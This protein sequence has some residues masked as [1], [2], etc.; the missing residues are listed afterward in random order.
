MKT[1]GFVIRNFRNIGICEGDKSQEAFLRLTIGEQHGGLIILIGENG[2][3]K[4][5]VLQALAKFGNSYLVSQGSQKL[6]G[7]HVLSQDD[8]P[9]SGGLPIVALAHQ[10][11][12]YYLHYPQDI[13]QKSGAAQRKRQEGIALDLGKHLDELQNDFDN[14]DIYLEQNKHEIISPIKILLKNSFGG[15]RFMR[16]TIDPLRNRDDRSVD[17]LDVGHSEKLNCSFVVGYKEVNVKQNFADYI[18]NPSLPIQSSVVKEYGYRICLESDKE[19]RSGHYNV[20][21]NIGS[22]ENVFL[23]PLAPKL[24]DKKQ[25]FRIPRI[26]FYDETH[27]CD[28]D[29]FVTFDKVEKSKFFRGG[30]TKNL[31]QISQHFNALYG[32][33]S[34]DGYRFEVSIEKDRIALEIYKGKQAKP[35]L[36]EKQSASFRK[37]FNLIFGIIQMDSLQEGDIIL[38]DDVE[39]CLSISAQREL[40]K[41]LKG[42]GQKNGILFIV[43]THSP[44]MIDRN[45][46]DEIRLL[47]AKDNGL[48]TEIV[49]FAGLDET[50]RKN[51]LAE[52][53]G[54]DLRKFSEACKQE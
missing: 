11:P 54:M 22:N 16:C 43:S 51:T 5:N 46:P 2:S 29:L 7:M 26:V 10:E 44:F 47:K 28:D 21:M 33:K 24:M 8:A 37:I 35:L 1:S 25:Q 27:F 32:I 53:V 6:E 20:Y 40:R 14:L 42:F 52:I 38:I 12:A 41:F 50:S 4:S 39:T 17:E 19:S 48:G 34:E 49:D 9:E 23:R 15:G 45:C 18:D 13:V 31:T 3:G 30:V 36:L